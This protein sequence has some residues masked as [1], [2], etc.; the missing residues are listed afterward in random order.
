MANFV[1]ESMASEYPSSFEIARPKRRVRSSTAVKTS[2][3][4]SEC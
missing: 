1:T 4:D 3:V 2:L